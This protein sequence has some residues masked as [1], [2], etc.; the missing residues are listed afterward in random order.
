M[1]N[2]YWQEENSHLHRLP[3]RVLTAKG[4]LRAHPLQ[5]PRQGGPCTPRLEHQTPLAPNS[6]IGLSKYLSP[7]T[8]RCAQ[9]RPVCFHLQ[10]ATY[11]GGVQQKS[12]IKSDLRGGA[13]RSACSREVIFLS[14]KCAELGARGASLFKAQGI[15]K[16][17]LWPGDC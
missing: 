17:L 5:S 16:A 2:N 9:Q 7:G 14:A 3:F 6:P 10:K 13:A 8:V 4:A 15:P 1:N 11:S 12:L